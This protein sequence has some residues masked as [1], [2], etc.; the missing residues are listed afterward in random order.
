MEKE[1]KEIMATMK[2]LDAW[3]TK[4]LTKA[5]VKDYRSKPPKERRRIAEWM[6]RASA[7]EEKRVN[8]Q[9]AEDERQGRVVRQKVKKPTPKR[10]EMAS[11]TKLRNLEAKH[12][13][14]FR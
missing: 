13:N 3:V 9:I 11:T 1:R 14:L 5:Q 4:D 2:E 7:A 6:K 10:T 12:R 8:K